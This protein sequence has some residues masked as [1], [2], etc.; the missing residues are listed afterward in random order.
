[1]NEFLVFR[2][3]YS[4]EEA[5]SLLEFF[6]EKGIDCSI[7]KHRPIVDKVYIG[8]NYD[9]EFHI[10]IKGSEFNKAN[11][12]LDFQISQNISQIESDYYL[13]SF[14]D[15]ELLEIIEKPDEW[16]NQDL[17]ISKKI[18][19]DRGFSI[20]EAEIT[21]KKL[22][23]IKNLEKPDKEGGLFIILGYF[24]SLFFGLFG[25][26]FGLLIINSKKTLPDGRK[27]FVY[28][29]RTR[30]HGKNILIIGLIMTTLVFVRILTN[31]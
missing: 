16:N 14:T 13:H 10:T 28:D 20:S 15:E 24:F 3:F 29:I 11:E 23:R 2:S 30:G 12:I 27:V 17:V 22:D 7:V 19:Q 9:R 6:K 5:L 18:L 1:M 31:F 26:G 25:I 4:E 8:T 21:E